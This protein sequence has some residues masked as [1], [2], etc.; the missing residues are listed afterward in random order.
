MHSDVLRRCCRLCLHLPQLSSPRSPA[1][2]CG[3]TAC[4]YLRHSNRLQ[5]ARWAVFCRWSTMTGVIRNRIKQSVIKSMQA[6]LSP[7]SCSSTIYTHGC[8][9]GQLWSRSKLIGCSDTG[10]H[11]SPT[12]C[13]DMYSKWTTLSSWVRSSYFILHRAAATQQQ[14]RPAADRPPIQSPK[15]RSSSTALF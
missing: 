9:I 12:D 7:L 3:F 14:G 13:N 5:R 8:V 15:Q 1:V 10:S 4:R 11:Y 6:L 2:H